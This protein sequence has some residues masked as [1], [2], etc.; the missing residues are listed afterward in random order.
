MRCVDSAAWVLKST[1]VVSD[2]SEKYL[3]E[4]KLKIAQSQ[5]KLPERVDGTEEV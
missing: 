4:E 1:T 2:A 5:E 3:G